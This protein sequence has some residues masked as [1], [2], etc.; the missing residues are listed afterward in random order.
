[1]GKVHR[2]VAPEEAAVKDSTKNAILS[3]YDKSHLQEFADALVRLG[4][5]LYS[6]EGTLAEIR[7]LPAK[8]T[9]GKEGLPNFV[10]K[11]VHSLTK[12]TGR[13]DTL[14]GRV[15]TLNDKIHSAILA[16]PRDSAQIE[17]F[18]KNGIPIIE[19]VVVNFYP[20]WAVVSTPNVSIEEAVENIDIGGPTMVRAA[21]KNFE[22]VIT[23][24][25]PG[26]YETVVEHLERGENTLEW[27]Q[28]LALKAFQHVAQYDQQIVAYFE[29][30]C[31][32]LTTSSLTS[33]PA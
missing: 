27:R 4:W 8:E 9:G 31:A 30:A 12:V 25:D 7:H 3:V 33:S 20:F 22:H 28:T 6:T 1:M 26:D 11:G 14:N 13:H 23:V 29:R 32:H 19:M 21:A 16:T 17:E 15:K 5:Q 24:V 10:V 2:L 18:K